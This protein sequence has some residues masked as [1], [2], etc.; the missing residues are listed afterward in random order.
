MTIS[1]NIDSLIEHVT[2]KHVSNT[3]TKNQAIR[4][5]LDHDPA[6]RARWMRLYD[7]DAKAF[8]NKCLAWQ[9]FVE[10]DAR[11]GNYV[12]EFSLEPDE[13]VTTGVRHLNDNYLNDTEV[14]L[15]RGKVAPRQIAYSPSKDDGSE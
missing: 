1:I 2:E 5:V 11:N 7:R 9:A 6:L 15:V 10:S 12:A 8:T 3:R 13:I 14:R 4:E